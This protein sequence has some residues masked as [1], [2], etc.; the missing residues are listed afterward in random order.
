MNG[1][2]LALYPRGWRDRYGSE[3]ADLAD[4]LITAGETTPLRAALD[5]LTGAV[6]ERWRVVA[7]WAVLGPATW[8]CAAACGIALA[9]SH[10]LH[11]AGA[12]RPYFVT[13]WAGVLLMVIELG[14]LLMELTE[15][16]RGRRSPHWRDRALRTSQRGFWLAA[17]VSM[18]GTTLVLYLVPPVIPGAAIHPGGG[19]FA[20]GVVTLIAGVGL[21]G[22]S[23]RALEGRYFNF[24]IT[25]SPDQAV[26]TRGPYRLLRHPGHSG[27]LLVCMGFGL[28][29]ANWVALAAATLL[30]LA[31]IV[32]RI[33]VE[34]NALVAT[35]G[36]R[37]RCYA[38]GHR[39]LVPLIW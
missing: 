5:L 10:T 36:E 14:W 29:S 20:V 13:H 8:A 31:V 22:W 11:G 25:V 27:I 26:V 32:W 38:S 19:A 24:A 16:V 7:R 37:Y 35:L 4:E 3:V 12:T 34:E 28:A 23:F 33:R 30:P 15:F 6:V 17:W 21:R 2:L 1:R 39:R 18:I 9:V